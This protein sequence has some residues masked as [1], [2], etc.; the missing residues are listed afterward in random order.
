MLQKKRGA[1]CTLILVLSLLLFNWEVLLGEGHLNRCWYLLPSLW[2]FAISFHSDLCQS[3]EWPVQLQGRLSKGNLLT[4]SQ[5]CLGISSLVLSQIWAFHPGMQLVHGRKGV[6]R[7]SLVLRASQQVVHIK[8]GARHTSIVGCGFVRNSF[9]YVEVCSLYTH[10]GKSGIMN[11]CWI[12]SNAFSACWVDHV[13]FVFSFVDVL[14]HIDL[15]MLNYLFDPG[16]NLTWL[17]CKIFF[18]NVLLDSVC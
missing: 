16:M 9:C 11:G 14:Y 15:C 18:F 2:V 12:L 7:Q 5:V 17:W 4:R 1:H 6:E 8:L 10:F 3:A 13:V